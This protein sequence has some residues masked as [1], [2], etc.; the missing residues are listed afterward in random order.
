[1]DK[2][3]FIE[4]KVTPYKP[5]LGSYITRPIGEHSTVA[6]SYDPWAPQSGASTYTYGTIALH[7]AVQPALKFMIELLNEFFF[8]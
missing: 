1:M 5:V 2:K 8:F 3:P 4:P 6:T 7:P